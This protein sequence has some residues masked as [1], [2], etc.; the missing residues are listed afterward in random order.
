MSEL[1]STQAPAQ[2]LVPGAQASAH[3]PREQTRPEAQRVPQSPQ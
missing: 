1:T 2:E 3:R